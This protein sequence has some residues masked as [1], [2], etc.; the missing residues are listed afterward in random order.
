MPRQN[1]RAGQQVRVSDPDSPFYDYMGH[2]V[3]IVTGHEVKNSSYEYYRVTI[4]V[5]VGHHPVVRDGDTVAPL[6]LCF[7]DDQLKA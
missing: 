7:R 2:V 4:P 3:G 1:F 5:P 6:K